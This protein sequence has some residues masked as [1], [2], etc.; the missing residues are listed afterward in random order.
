MQKIL[1]GLSNVT[2][3]FFFSVPFDELIAVFILLPVISVSLPTTSQ[4]CDGGKTNQRRLLKVLLLE[5]NV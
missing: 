5:R 1:P 2:G 3:L 4:L